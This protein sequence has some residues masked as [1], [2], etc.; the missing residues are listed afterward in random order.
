LHELYADR[1]DELNGF[2]TN[3]VTI[4]SNL[5]VPKTLNICRPQ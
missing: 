3:Q 1:E 2:T 5:E 4:D